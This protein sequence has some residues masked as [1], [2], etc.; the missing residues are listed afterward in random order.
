MKLC[1][2]VFAT[3][4]AAGQPKLFRRLNGG[5]AGADPVA[6]GIEGGNLCVLLGE[7]AGN[8]MIG[9]NRAESGAEQRV[10]AGGEDFELFAVKAVAD[11]VKE[12]P[13]AF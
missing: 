10:G 2:C 12:H 6:V 3:G 11:E 9:R 7:L 5:L 8:R 13:R 4:A 1:G